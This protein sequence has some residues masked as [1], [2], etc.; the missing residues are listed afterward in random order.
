MPDYRMN[1][2]KPIGA[3]TLSSMAGY[4]VTSR[5]AAPPKPPVPEKPVFEVTPDLAA[6][7]EGLTLGE[8]MSVAIEQTDVV[9]ENDDIVKQGIEVP[10]DEEETVSKSRTSTNT[11]MSKT[12]GKTKKDKTNATSKSE[13][14]E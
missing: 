6:E 13:K 10:T 9:N 11:M 7:K 3:T 2:S 12:K 8:A 14:P 5:A 1:K 4:N